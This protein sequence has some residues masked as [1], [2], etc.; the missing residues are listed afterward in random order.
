MDKWAL[1]VMDHIWTFVIIFGVIA[2]AATIL[3]GL[4]E[5]TC[6]DCLN[7]SVPK[8]AKVCSKCG[9]RFDD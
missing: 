8:Q 9:Y 5:K 1:Y 7:K 2:L 4:F 3:K 6:P